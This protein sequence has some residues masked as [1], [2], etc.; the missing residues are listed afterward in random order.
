MNASTLAHRLLALIFLSLLPS[1]R[2]F[3][4]T[5]TEVLAKRGVPINDLSP[6]ER[7]RRITSYAQSKDEAPFLIAYYDDDGSQMLKSPLRVLR[8]DK[9]AGFQRTDL[10]GTEGPFSGVMHEPNSMCLGSAL[11]I[12]Q[13]AGSVYIDT[14][15]NP[16]AGCV[17]VL[18]QN[19]KFKA[20]LE[21]WVIGTLGRILILHGNEV[22]FADVHPST[23]AVYDPLSDKLMQV[24]PPRG[25]PRRKVFSA[26]L[27]SHLP[28][29]QWCE[30]ENKACDPE[31][32]TSDIDD[33]TADDLKQTFS[34]TATLSPEGFG[35]KAESAIRKSATRYIF[36]LRNAKWIYAEHPLE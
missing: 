4:E 28:T 16:S 20:C 6:S 36:K 31:T 10:I 19:L 3:S 22:H 12:E 27:A 7:S 35:D 5:L 26:A 32:F 1:H 25:D 9:A 18:S 30:H 29:R 14:H 17:L 15:I 13:A 2:I 23:A 34:F 33:V 24:Y 8:Y 21:G 11:D